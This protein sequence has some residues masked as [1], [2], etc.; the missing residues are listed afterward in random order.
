M[1]SELQR[2]KYCQASPLS[3]V[4]DERDGNQK[5]KRPKT[6]G[7]AVFSFRG[8]SAEKE[9]M[10]SITNGQASIVSN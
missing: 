7:D 4:S 1:N 9:N 3:P 6:K 2:L 10:Q 5:G 8:D